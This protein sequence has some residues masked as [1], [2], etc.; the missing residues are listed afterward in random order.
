MK[1]GCKFRLCLCHI[2]GGTIGF[3]SNRYQKDYKGEAQTPAKP[4]A[5]KEKAAKAKK[6]PVEKKAKAAKPAKE[7]KPKVK[8]EAPKAK[9]PSKKS[10]S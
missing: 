10:E 5:T 6:A 9:K 7:A 2:K 1:S 8:D 3:S 4:K